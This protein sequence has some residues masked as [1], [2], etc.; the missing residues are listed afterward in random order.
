VAPQY[1]PPHQFVAFAGFIQAGQAGA[2]NLA[3]YKLWVPWDT[4]PAVIRRML[5]VGR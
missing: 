3:G 5:A 1:G 4:P 2:W